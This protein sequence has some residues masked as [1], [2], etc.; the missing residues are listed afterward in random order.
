M[1]ETRQ[2]LVNEKRSDTLEQMKKKNEVSLKLVDKS[3]IDRVN[4][5]QKMNNTLQTDE[6]IRNKM[7]THFS[8]LEEDRLE[9]EKLINSRSKIKINISMI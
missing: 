1:K 5:L 4:R 7:K 3:K 8:K 9:I 2:R 6:T